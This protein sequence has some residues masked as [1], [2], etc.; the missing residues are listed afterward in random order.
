[1]HI[2]SIN[3]KSD[4]ARPVAYRAARHEMVL[5]LAPAEDGNGNGVEEFP[6]MAR[7]SKK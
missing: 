4:L 3:G 7:R 6:P 5:N 2:K 1:V